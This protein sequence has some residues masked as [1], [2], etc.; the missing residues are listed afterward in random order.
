MCNF[1]VRTF[2]LVT[3]AAQWR[4]GKKQNELWTLVNCHPLI[5]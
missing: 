4:I 2:A 3:S 1:C 5:K